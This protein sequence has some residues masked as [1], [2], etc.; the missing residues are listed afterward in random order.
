M[1][2]QGMTSCWLTDFLWLQPQ[3]LMWL[4]TKLCTVH[5]KHSLVSVR[6]LQQQGN[7]TVLRYDA[8]SLGNW[9]PT[10]GDN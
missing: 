7:T 10:S 5:T 9:F 6:F 1:R 8:M 2:Q 3:E 4:L